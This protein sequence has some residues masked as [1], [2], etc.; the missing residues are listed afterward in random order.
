MV[1]FTSLAV[2]ALAAIPAFAHPG[3]DIAAEIRERAEF[4]RSPEYQGLGQCADAIKARDH[5]MI[6]RRM[7]Q[8]QALQE[9]RGL[10]RRS[11]TDVLNKDHKS[12]KAVT[13]QS[14]HADIFGSNSSCILQP[15][16]TEGPY[17]E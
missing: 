11:L 13:P 7:E 12:T 3:H 2:A 14:S 4:Q 5:I 15:E 9:K 17:C 1:H 10:E 6:K 16:T 8:V